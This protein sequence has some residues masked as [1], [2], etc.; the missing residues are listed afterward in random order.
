M[1]KAVL[2]FAAFVLA[3]A[4]FVV[5]DLIPVS[6]REEA[7]RLL[8]ADFAALN[9]GEMTLTELGE[10]TCSLAETASPAVQEVLWAGAVRIFTR[11][12][13]ANGVA[14]AQRRLEAV[15]RPF[16]ANGKEAVLRLGRFGDLSFVRCPTGTVDLVL[17]MSGKKT[18]HVRLTHPYWI[19]KYP[20]TRRESAFYP[21]LDPAS[22]GVVLDERALSAYVNANRAMAEGLT[23]HFT[24]R[25]AGKLPPGHVVRLPTL[26]EWEHAFHA[27]A[28]EGDFADLRHIRHNDEL[29]RRLYYDYDADEPRRK[30]LHNAWGIG[31]WCPQEKVLDIVDATKLVRSISDSPEFFQVKELPMPAATSDWAF[32]CTNEHAVSL[33]RMPSWARWKAAARGFGQDWCPMRLVIAPRFR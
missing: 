26:A 25:L 23:R 17:D 31:D 27:G 7:R 16:A 19:M 6:P 29:G 15:R 21:P 9:R 18:A 2:L 20:L 11:A 33:I 28:T 4:R 13:D 10:K 5:A 3:V 24:E 14:A 12:G 1:M 22:S 8:A 32:A 30:K